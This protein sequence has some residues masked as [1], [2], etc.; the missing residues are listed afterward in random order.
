MERIILYL[1]AM[2]N[3]GVGLVLFY[4]KPRPFGRRTYEDYPAETRGAACRRASEN[5]P[6]T[7][8][9]FLRSRSFPRNAGTGR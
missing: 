6:R 5:R 4:R 3:L 1:L 7:K 8:T 2:A 9:K